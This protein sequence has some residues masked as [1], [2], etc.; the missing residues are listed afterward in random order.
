MKYFHTGCLLAPCIDETDNLCVRRCG[1]WKAEQRFR[2]S[3]QYSHEELRSIG[4]LSTICHGKEKLFVM[5][6]FEIFIW[7]LTKKKQALFMKRTN[8]INSHCFRYSVTVTVAVLLC[9]DF[10]AFW[11]C[12]LASTGS[13]IFSYILTFPQEVKQTNK[14]WLV[15]DQHIY[16]PLKLNVT[17]AI[18]DKLACGQIN[19]SVTQDF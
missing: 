8:I 7:K 18:Y 3:T 14:H 12:H 17:S 9:C 4:V 6:E 1:L 15:T 11:I 5:F 2:Q 16:L 19:N 13:P 10:F